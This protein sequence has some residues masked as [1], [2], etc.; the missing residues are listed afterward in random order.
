MHFTLRI[1]ALSAALCAVTPAAIAAQVVLN[2]NEYATVTTPQSVGATQGLQFQGAF[3]YGVDMLDANLDTGL[4]FL[5]DASADRG[6]F[7]LNK[8]RGQSSTDIVLTLAQSGVS[9]TAAASAVFFQSISFNFWTRGTANSNLLFATGAN[10]IVETSITG[11]GQD[12]W[13]NAPLTFNFD[14]LEQVTALRFTAGGVPFALDDMTVTLTTA[15][16]P[17]GNVPEPAS[18]GL[19]GVALLAAGAASRRKQRG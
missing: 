10:G 7:V 6:G 18:Y 13:S 3:G 16:D 4:G 11:G 9:T 17:G 8:Q 14:P 15:T 2:F 5:K 12:F 19:V 1:V